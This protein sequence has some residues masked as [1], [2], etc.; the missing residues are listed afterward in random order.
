MKRLASIILALLTAIM[1][2]SGCAGGGEKRIGDIVDF[3]DERPVSLTAYSDD[4]TVG[5]KET[6]D[7][8]VIKKIVELY[9]NR[10]YVR[11]DTPAPGSNAAVEF[12]YG[13]GAMLKLSVNAITG[14]DGKIY[15]PSSPADGLAAFIEK[16]IKAS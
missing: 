16:L 15:A 8:E 11:T 2:F 4:P 12:K 13:D 6:I 10:S 3:P 14:K 5:S 9:K 1:L 7:A